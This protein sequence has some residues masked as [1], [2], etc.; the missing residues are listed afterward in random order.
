MV[1]RKGI[2]GRALAAGSLLA[3]CCVAAGA[4]P[5]LLPWIPGATTSVVSVATGAMV[6]LSGVGS[7]STGA[8]P[9]LGSAVSV[10]ANGVLAFG[11][12]ASAMGLVSCW[13][14]PGLGSAAPAKGVPAAFGSTAAVLGLGLCWAG[15]GLG[16]VI[17][18]PADGMLVF[19]STATAMGLA[20]GSVFV[21]GR[22]LLV[23]TLVP[24]GPLGEAPALPASTLLAA[25]C[26]ADGPSAA[27]GDGVG[28]VEKM[29]RGW[30]VGLPTAPVGMGAGLLSMGLVEKT[31]KGRG[32]GLAV[33]AVSVA[34]GPGLLLALP[35]H[36]VVTTST[37]P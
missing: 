3:G 36:G 31:T 14:G 1:S 15:L 27:G 5:P 24:T 34:R 25:F 7:T 12:T 35:S 18:A 10:S 6:T 16:C 17:F 26:A 37:G 29:V 4:W 22:G 8:R 28:L 32:A 13:A 19:G 21:T 30:G 23:S 33:A 11:A 9:G 2:S 20:T